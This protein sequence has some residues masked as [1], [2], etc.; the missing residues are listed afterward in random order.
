[1]KETIK[2]Q[3]KRMKN[4]GYSIQWLTEQI[5]PYIEEELKQQDF[6]IKSD[7]PK[8]TNLA[9]ESRAKEKWFSDVL[10]SGKY[11][12]SSPLI[13]INPYRI[14]PLTA[15][16]LFSTKE[17]CTVRY[18]ILDK[19]DVPNITNEITE[20]KKDH[21]IP[22]LGLYADSKNR[23]LL[24]VI[25]SNGNITKKTIEI[26]TFST[27]AALLDSVVVKENKK[28][29]SEDLIYVSGGF[30]QQSYMFDKR[31]NIRFYFN[32]KVKLYGTHML[33]NGH[34]LFPEEAIANPTFSNPHSNIFHEMDFMGRVYKTY[35]V[36]KGVHHYAAEKG[37]G[38]NILL[39]SST[40]APELGM[41]NAVIEIDRQTGDVVRTL[42]L[43]PLFD[44]TYLNRHDWAHIN[45]IQYLQD[46]DAVI[47]SLRNVHS[48]VKIGW[49]SQQLEWVLGDVKFWEPT[50]MMDKVLKPTDDTI[51]WFY[52]QHAAEVLSDV[53]GK[54]E[55]LIYDNH[56]AM[57]RPVEHFV[58][59]EESNLMIY[60]IDEKE[61]TVILKKIYPLGLFSKIRSNGV[62]VKD[63]NCMWAMSAFLKPKI[64]DFSAMVDEMD[65][66]TG[67]LLN[68]FAL[69]KDFFSAYPIH[70]N[71]ED[72][73]KALDVQ[74]PYEVGHVILPTPLDVKEIEESIKNAQ[75]ADPEYFDSLLYSKLL[76]VKETDNEIRH[77]YAVGTKHAYHL[78]KD[79]TVQKAP[80][81]FADQR[82]YITFPLDVCEKDCY[83]F[84]LQTN[85]NMYVLKDTVE[86]C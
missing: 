69:K 10:A 78:D 6:H 28:P 75:P 8:W 26:S 34:L 76:L 40:L 33:S 80:N 32:K 19:E 14:A 2:N 49:E 9:L 85:D 45:S 31:G 41:E 68:K 82:Y 11:T 18:T 59:T 16:V 74:S 25:D 54:K 29:C 84:Y 48:I 24:E 39:A 22:V 17:M 30:S 58:P 51:A 46:E 67:E 15:L 63:K 77:M 64:E 5:E 83:T 50:A 72:M 47:L 13:L 86:I 55:L 35:M 36:E 81:T 12:V 44:K 27:A 42:D 62:F 61:R 4:G 71:A 1:M 43:N 37:V 53:D 66:T 20:A 70:F 79:N 57:R 73:A 52:Q 56:I 23:V 21:R 60:E 38:G 7:I 65:Y 3:L